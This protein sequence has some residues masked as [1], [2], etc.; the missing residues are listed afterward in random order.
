[1]KSSDHEPATWAQFL[2]TYAAIILSGLGFALLLE[3][4]WG[5]N[6]YRS[7][8]IFGGILFS[9]L[10]SGHPRVMYAV[11]G[12]WLAQVPERSLRPLLAVLGLVLLVGALLLPEAAFRS[13]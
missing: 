5:I 11:V 2:G 9:T 1:V 12:T 8:W 4:W 7:I 10:S 6:P 3:R 13:H